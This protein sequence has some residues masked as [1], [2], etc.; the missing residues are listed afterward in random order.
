MP[1][2]TPKQAYLAAEAEAERAYKAMC[3]DWTDANKEA[4]RAATQ[5]ARDAY[6]AAYPKTPAT[7]QKVD[8]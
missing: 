5:A 4:Y 2:P 6:W 3:A 7:G 1:S 8:A